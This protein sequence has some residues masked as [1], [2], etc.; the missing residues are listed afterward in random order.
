MSSA[1]DP[2]ASIAD[3]AAQWA[4]RIDRGD[5]TDAERFGLNDWLHAD[6]RH[7]GALIRAQAGLTF[8]GGPDLPRAK[9][10]PLV[11]PAPARTGWWRRQA[12]QRHTLMAM[13]A[14]ATL[15]AFGWLL[16]SGGT[17]LATDPGEIRRIALADG[18]VAMI[19][20][21]SEIAVDYDDDTRRIDIAAGEAWFKVAHN[22]KRPFVVNAG[23]VHVRATGTAF[24]VRHDGGQVRVVVT[25]GS[26]LVWRQGEDKRVAMKAGEQA[27][28][29]ATAEAVPITL[30]QTGDGQPLAWREGR[31]TLSNMPVAEA[32][33]EF[34]R[35]N[36]RQI[37]IADEQ[38]A[39]SRMV[40]YFNLENPERFARAV[41]DLSGGIV[42]SKGNYIVIEMP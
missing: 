11:H 22:A 41:A 34:N 30:H 19:N 36:S 9:V 21:R 32:V 23:K 5:L 31:L 27:Q 38:I 7:R 3:L 40:G 2:C 6:R 10:L 35:F 18:S 1:T 15:V 17:H 28:L 42:T 14:C 26:V 39:A 37:L 13:T 20:A 25:D 24:A 4:V 8:L 33:A 16:L 29:L 12:V